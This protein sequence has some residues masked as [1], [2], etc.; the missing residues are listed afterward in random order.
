[1]LAFAALLLQLNTSPS[2]VCISAID[3]KGVVSPVECQALAPNT[4]NEPQAFVMPESD[5]K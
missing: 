4:G 1:M 3:D 5:R 2:M